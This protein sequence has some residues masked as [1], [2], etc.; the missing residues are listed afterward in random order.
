[1]INLNFLLSIDD[2]PRSYKEAIF[3]NDNESWQ[4][5]MHEDVMALDSCD[6]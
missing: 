6:T 3:A 4:L 2:N 1:M 5:A